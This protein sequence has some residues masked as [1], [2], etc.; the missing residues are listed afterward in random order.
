[1]VSNQT[2]SEMPVVT[3]WAVI[4]SFITAVKELTSWTQHDLGYLNC[5]NLYT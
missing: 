2:E 3:M 4:G 1:M 5:F